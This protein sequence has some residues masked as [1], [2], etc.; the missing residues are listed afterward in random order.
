MSYTLDDLLKKAQAKLEGVHPTVKAKAL[1]LIPKAYEKGYKLIIT[2][3]L[4][5]I[6]AQNLFYA[7]GR[8]TA[9][10]K[11]VGITDVTGEP[12]EKVVTKAKGGTSYHN[13]GLA[14][15]FGVL[16]K[17]EDDVDWDADSK[18]KAV[19]QLGKAI[20]LEWGGD[21]KSIKDTPHFQ[22]TF[23][24]SIA[25]LKAGKRPS[26]STVSVHPGIAVVKL[27]IESELTKTLQ[28]NLNWLGFTEVGDADGIAGQK[29]VDAIK[30][31]QT[32]YNLDADGIAGKDTL[33]KIDAVI[34]Q[35]KEQATVITPDPK[36]TKTMPTV[37]SFA[38]TPIRVKTTVKAGVYK[39]ADLS[40]KQRLIDE[41]TT[42]LVYGNTYAAWAVNDGFVQMKDVEPV[43]QTLHTGGI[44]ASMQVELK[45]FMSNIGED[46]KI[47]FKA[48]GGNP[49]AEITSKGLHLV[50]VLQFL[51]SKAW[52]YK[53]V[54]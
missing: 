27:G 21:F 40:E 37:T 32:K 54:K 6:H 46:T 10:L 16:N 14:F 7:K 8:T 1:E 36:P 41:G 30:A 3:G 11:A 22:I 28:K 42:F 13:Y 25:D 49:Y 50:Q 26:G 17:A 15:D 31:F 23:G 2:Q 45:R 18:F 38:E 51:K 19:G 48:E 43:Q 29:T 39:N 24:L 34:K 33:A 5:T 52:Y 47:V 20:G 4:R 12:K 35:K 53:E 9:Q 44:N